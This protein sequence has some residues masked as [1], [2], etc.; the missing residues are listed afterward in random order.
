[1]IWDVESIES[2]IQPL[3]VILTSGLTNR[4]RRETYG[5]LQLHSKGIPA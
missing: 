5:N 3:G 1:V 4:I 2:R